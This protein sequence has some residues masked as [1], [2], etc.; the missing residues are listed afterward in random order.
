MSPWTRSPST[1]VFPPRIRP[2]RGGSERRPEKWVVWLVISGVLS[3][4]WGFWP[5]TSGPREWTKGVG[6]VPGLDVSH[7]HRGSEAVSLTCRVLAQHGRGVEIGRQQHPE[8]RCECRTLP[9]VL[10]GCCALQK[11][12]EGATCWESGRTG[13]SCQLG[14]N[15]GT[16][17]A[18]FGEQ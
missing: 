3:V 18:L 4:K 6:F 1:L 12:L 17:G 9:Q 10:M 11:D 8:P 7:A 2:Q 5:E 14:R 16:P 13:H 15:W